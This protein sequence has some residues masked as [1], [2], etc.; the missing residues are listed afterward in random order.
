M[1]AG[2]LWT[3]GVQLYYRD[4]GSGA[5][6]VFL[7]GGL[8]DSRM[9]DDQVAFFR[10]AYR[11]IAYDAR[12]HGRSEQAPGVVEYHTDLKGLLQRLDAEPAW[13]VGQS[14]GARTALCC[15]LEYPDAV[16]GLVLVAPGLPGYTFSLEVQLASRELGQALRNGNPTRAADIFLRQWVIGTRR[17]ISQVSPRMVE[18]A[19]AMIVDNL[20]RP[21]PGETQFNEPRAIERLGEISVP[22]LVVCGAADAPDILAVA[23]QIATRVAGARKELIPGV[24]HALNMEI[25]DRFNQIVRE[26]LLTPRRDGA[27]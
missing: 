15:A 14:L 10:T 3:N 25:P 6:L 24:A 16:R 19:R 13:L 9:W 17:N 5:P 1:P 12:G 20:T 26:F 11:T 21:S 18:R 8:L 4:E 23:D 7:H 27:F 22:T 2:L